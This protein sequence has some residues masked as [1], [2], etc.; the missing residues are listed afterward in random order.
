MKAK[1]FWRLGG[2]VQGVKEK[3]R[4][5]KKQSKFSNKNELFEKS[6]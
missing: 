4:E 3:S 2:M 5:G 6:I 1:M